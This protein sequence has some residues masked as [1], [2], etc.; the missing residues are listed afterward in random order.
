MDI[1]FKI[2]DK[3]WGRKSKIFLTAKNIFS[4]KRKKKWSGVILLFKVLQ[5][6]S[7]MRLLR[8]QIFLR[9]PRNWQRQLCLWKRVSRTDVKMVHRSTCFILLRFEKN[10]FWGL[11]DFVDW[12]CFKAKWKLNIFL[13]VGYVE[14]PSRPPGW[15]FVSP[16]KHSKVPP[17]NRTISGVLRF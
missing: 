16:T 10:V 14:M 13:V 3:S 11:T 6:T 12:C 4:P 1:S 9:S 15:H 2:F 17:K 7:V 8:S 5:A